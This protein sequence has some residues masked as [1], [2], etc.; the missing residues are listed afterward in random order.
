MLFVHLQQ[1]QL[2]SLFFKLNRSRNDRM[3]Q[4]TSMTIENLNDFTG[5]QV[6][7][8]DLVILA[9]RDYVFRRTMSFWQKASVD[10]KSLIQVPGI[11]LDASRRLVIP[12]SYGRILRRR[13]QKF[14]IGRK[15]DMPAVERAQ[16]DVDEVQRSLTRRDYR[17]PPKSWDTAPI[18]RPIF[19]YPEVISVN[20]QRTDIDLH[21]SIHSTRYYQGSV[22]AEA[23]SSHR[24]RVRRHHTHGFAYTYKSWSVSPSQYDVRYLAQR[25]RHEW[26]HRTRQTRA[27]L[28]V[29][30]NWRKR[31]NL[32]VQAR[33]LQLVPITTC[34][35]SS[36]TTLPNSRMSNPIAWRTYHPMQKQ[37]IPHLQTKPSLIYPRY[38]LP[39]SSV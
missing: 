28:N 27:S 15:S 34:E 9:P 5:L 11:C 24:V 25:P 20:Q 14:R 1:Q 2:R 30:W 3:I 6:P 8:V 7:D 37:C 12:K 26:F 29:D 22:M 10:C 38:G 4:L 23:D 19:V 31:Q 21:Q 35:N 16:Y 39:V 32:C 33:F 17:H 36:K 13:Q 18:R